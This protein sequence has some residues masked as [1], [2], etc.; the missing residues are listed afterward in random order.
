MIVKRMSTLVPAQPFTLYKMVSNALAAATH[1]AL[2]PITE[3]G[4]RL[5]LSSQTAEQ[6]PLDAHTFTL[7]A[8]R[9][10]PMNGFLFDLG[11][12][13]TLF[14]AGSPRVVSFEDVADVAN[15][16]QTAELIPKQ[17][18]EHFRKSSTLFLEFDASRH[19]MGSPPFLETMDPYSSSS[20][21]TMIS[22]FSLY[23]NLSQ[24]SVLE[25]AAL[26]AHTS[27][28]ILSSHEDAVKADQAIAT[29]ADQRTFPPAELFF[30]YADTIGAGN[31]AQLEKLHA[32][33][34]QAVQVNLAERSKRLARQ[35]TKLPKKSFTY[36]DARL[37]PGPD[38][39][40]KQLE[41]SQTPVALI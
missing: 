40:L 18:W 10:I 11:Q 3:Y 16:C 19:E 17:V 30:L 13:R 14:A 38:G 32:Y 9:T 1:L 21:S 8:K 23:F 4:H 2:G 29:T 15:L 31:L 25:E 39:L 28:T 37:L 26:R 5:E 12:R 35:L 24:V 27:I 22:T 36:V 41:R 7:I 6:V 33:Q 20:F 34:P